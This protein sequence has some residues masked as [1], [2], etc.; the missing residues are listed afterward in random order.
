MKKTKV[1]HSN[2]PQERKICNETKQ[3]IIE[4]E[5]ETL[6]LRKINK[7]ETVSRINKIRCIREKK[8]T[9]NIEEQKTLG[10]RGN[11]VEVRNQMNTDIK[12]LKRY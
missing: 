1:I 10:V 7:P 9:A 8:L 2:H 5:T 4:R 11:Y 3:I 12:R 6:G